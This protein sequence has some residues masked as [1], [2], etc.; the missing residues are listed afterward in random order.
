MKFVNQHRLLNS[1]YESL[2]PGPAL[3]DGRTEEDWL[4]FLTEFATLINFYDQDNSLNGTWEPFLLKDP[5]FLMAAISGANY[6]KMYALYLNTCHKLEQLLGLGRGNE[7]L[8]HSFNQLF[9]QLINSFLKIKQWY[10][11]MANSKVNYP[12]KTYVATQIRT[13]FGNELQAIF[14]LRQELFRSGLI[15]GLAPVDPVLLE[16]F[17]GY[18]ARIWR[19][20]AYNGHYWELLG[21]SAL[22]DNTINDI[23]KALSHVAEALFNFLKVIITQA[24]IEYSRLLKLKS[25]FPDTTL[26][27]SF[28]HLLKVQ[29]AQLNGIADHHLRFY[30]RDVLMQTERKAV[31]DRAYLVATLTAK[32][33]FVSLPLATLFDAGLD[34]ERHPILF[35]STEEVVLNPAAIPMAYTLSRVPASNELSILQ[36]LSI[37]NPGVL[38]KDEEG[39]V[40][41][42]NTLGSHEPDP[43]AQQALGIAFASPMLLLREGTRNIKIFLNYTGS[44]DLNMLQGAQCYLSTTTDWL[45][46]TAALT[47]ENTTDPLSINITIALK[48]T[49]PAIE[50]F[51]EH[52]DGIDSS[53]PMF[54][55]VFNQVTEAKVA[56]PVLQAMKIEVDVTDMETF[57]LYNDY[58]ALSSK[59]S[60]PPFGPTPEKGSN[61][62]LG[63]NEIFSKPVE[64]LNIELSWATLPQ[65]P[66][67]SIYYQAYNLYLNKGLTVTKTPDSCWLK[68]IFSKKNTELP[69]TETVDEPYNNTCFVVDFQVLD[70]KNWEPVVFDSN[71]LFSPDGDGLS[72]LSPYSSTAIPLSACDPSLQNQSMKFTETSTGGFLK[73]EL[74]GPDYGFGTTIYPNV[75]SAVTLCN[76]Q[77]LYN[78]EDQPFFEQAQLP[79][80][81][82]LKS[83]TASYVASVQYVFNAESGLV[84]T[85]DSYPV[86]AF[87]YTPFTNYLVYDNLNELPVQKDTIGD[88]GSTISDASG[89]PLYASFNYDGFLYLAIDNL[90]P[91]TSFNIYFELAR[92]YVSGDVKLPQVEYYYLGTE[93]WAALVV[94]SDGT[95][96]LSSSGIVSLNIPADISLES[97]LMPKGCYWIAIVANDISHVAA[98]VLLS[99]NGISVQR[100]TTDPD[101][102]AQP[103]IPAGTITRTKMPFSKISSI[104][105]PFPSFGKR[106]AEDVRTMNRRVSQRLKTK[107]RAVSATDY[108]VLIKQGFEV[109]FDAVVIVD[110]LQKTT[111]VY[112]V[113]T[114]DHWT[115]AHAFIPMVSVDEEAQ[116]KLYLQKRTS[117]FS[118]LRVMNPEFQK[119]VVYAT[120]RILPGY[121]FSAVQQRLMQAL[122]IY[123]S[124]WIKDPGLQVAIYQ[125]ISDVQVAAFIKTIEGVEAVERLCFK[126]WIYRSDCTE[127]PENLEA[128]SV[129]KPL[130]KSALFISNMIHQISL[131][132]AAI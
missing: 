24:K 27:R 21:L 104:L 35:E 66:D 48:S 70:E 76:S 88:S 89:I 112:V 98:T 17:S 110:P 45:E 121:E 34:S 82:K 96:N 113:K 28:I 54:K 16:K 20:G 91:A 114:V 107:D 23:F 13:T 52:P 64:S 18:E 40:L 90:I 116:M 119:V 94:L 1:V 36:L 95:N 47:F 39:K 5:V 111:N 105:Q 75:V 84:A 19:E 128:I 63:S 41:S 31:A 4:R 50:R 85:I 12:L 120:I 72:S 131:N 56:V 77:I 58:G 101:L 9:D 99:T 130:I 73:M 71:L 29:Q 11:Y 43:A 46:V 106:A 51:L 78:N 32:D 37:S 118:L 69:A 83:F 25:S 79:F 117:A 38:Q 65:P 60:Y 62:I 125:D 87:L 124:P 86:Q 81:P 123:L 132:P 10:H 127:I 30:Y 59:V 74:T 102:A 6:A 93:G 26:L 55:L 33:A 80:T 53:W 57:Q 42:W 61:F 108:V 115:V 49:D 22:K 2:T 92:T 68:N 3:I 126:S 7:D 15:V 67:F 129:V 14:S 109:V 103:N 97:S 44:V 122:N 8:A 100:T